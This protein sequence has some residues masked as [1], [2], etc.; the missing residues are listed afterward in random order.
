MCHFLLSCHGKGQGLC[1]ER[2]FSCHGEKGVMQVS[3]KTQYVLRVLEPKRFLHRIF[4]HCLAR[5]E[6]QAPP[7]M[8]MFYSSTKLSCL[9]FVLAHLRKFPGLSE[10]PASPGGG[11]E[12]IR[13]IFTTEI[14]TQK[15]SSLLHI[16]GGLGR[17]F[18]PS[19]FTVLIG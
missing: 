12:G 9:G 11:T 8:Q 16:K 5:T 4:P 13:R 10:L 1:A 7:P 6:T 14:F 2:S 3:T 19:A 18:P 15:T 17:F